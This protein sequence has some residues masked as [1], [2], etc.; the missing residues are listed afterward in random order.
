MKNRA[1]GKIT[2]IGIH[3]I[4]ADVYEALGNYISTIDGVYFV[5]EIGSYV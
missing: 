5:G 2:S 3:G 1:I 4:I